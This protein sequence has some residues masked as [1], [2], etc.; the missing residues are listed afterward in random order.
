[1]SDAKPT[2][3]VSVVASDVDASIAFYRTLGVPIPDEA[4]WRSHHVGIPIDGSALDLDSVELTKGY[5]DGWSGTGVILIMRV[6]TREAVDEAYKRVVGA[7]HPGHLE[8]IDA[9]WGARYAVVLDPD[10]NQIGIMSP[11]DEL[12]GGAPPV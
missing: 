4:N 9:F 10:G 1:M 7:G 5:D 3:G 2:F 12:L 11:T 8:P 6:P